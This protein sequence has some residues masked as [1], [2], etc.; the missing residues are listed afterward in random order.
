MQHWHGMCQAMAMHVALTVWNGEMATVADFARRLLLVAVADGRIAARREVDA[1]GDDP[2]RWCAR[3]KAEGVTTLLCGA[4]TRHLDDVLQVAG[5]AVIDGCTGPVE[6]VLAAWLTDTVDTVRRQTPCR[7][8]WRGGRASSRPAPPAVAGPSASPSA[9]KAS[10]MRIAIPVQGETLDAPIDPRFGRAQRFLVVDAATGA[11]AL[12][13]NP[14]GGDAAH[15]AG[16]RTAAFVVELGVD[17]VV[18][19][20]IGPKAMDVLRQAGVRTYCHAGGTAA[21]A[22]A[23][24]AKDRLA[25]TR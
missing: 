6:A 2:A 5:I 15:G 16:L 18:G 10:P 19:W 20:A 11:S 14:H 21:E 25:E 17:A 12:H 9:T 4:I 8:R 7:H 3:L 23:L 1:P 13:V 22:V 24:L